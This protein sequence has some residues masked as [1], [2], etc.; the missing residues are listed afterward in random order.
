MDR[1]TAVMWILLV[2]AGAISG[3]VVFDRL[4]SSLDPAPSSEAEV[5]EARL[6]AITGVGGDV[7]ILVDADPMEPEIRSAVAAGVARLAEAP[8]VVEV[9]S[10][11]ADPRLV[12]HNGTA[13]LIVAGVAPAL[14]EDQAEELLTTVDLVASSLPAVTSVGGSV[15]LDEELGATAESD[16]IRADAIAVPL[17]VLLAGLALGRLR[18]AVVPMLIVITAVTVPLG[19]LLVLSLVTDVSVFAVNVVTMFGVGLAVDYGLLI[20]MRYREERRRHDNPA[21]AIEV[22]MATAGRA[23]RYSGV[24][25][26]AALAGLLVFEE[27]LLRSLAYGGIAAVAVAVTAASTIVPLVLRR[28]PDILPVRAAAPSE[29]GVLSR[30]A[31]LVARHPAENYCCSPPSSIGRPS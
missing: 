1:A 17:V 19:I 4:D 11:V 24:T 30:I 10:G 15:V 9:A 31:R 6:A 14:M 26:A 16:L 18:T 22:T 25:V 5:A 28:Y 21:A 29:S 12:S 2:M 27:S 13:F 23:V 3:V 8:G 7:A 20:G